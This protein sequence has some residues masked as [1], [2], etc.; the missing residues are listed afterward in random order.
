VAGENLMAHLRK[1]IRAEV[2][3]TLNAVTTL[4][5]KV[6]KTRL[7]PFAQDVLPRVCVY[8]MDES[9][10]GDRTG[11]ALQRALSLNIEIIVKANDGIDD[12]VDD[13]AELIEIALAADRSRGGLAYDTT[14]TSTR[15][16]VHQEGEEKTGHGVLSYTVVY[17]SSR[18]NPA[19]TNP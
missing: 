7:K 16:S 13:L 19:N 6:H 2:V 12:A 10:E 5:G 17:R 3:A 11:H 18:A 9:S 15:L 1:R 4:S 14:L 8:T